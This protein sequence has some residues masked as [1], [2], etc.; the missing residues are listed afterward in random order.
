[1]KSTHFFLDPFTDKVSREFRT[2]IKKLFLLELSVYEIAQTFSSP[3]EE[4]GGHWAFPC[5]ILS[6]KLRKSPAYISEELSQAFEDSSVCEKVFNKGPYMNFFFK[7]DFL[8]KELLDSITT[9]RFFKIPSKK[10]GTYL[11]EYSQPNTHKELHIGH[12]RN[13]CFGLSL[14]T[15]LKKRGFP[16]HTCTYLGDMGTHVAKCLWY[17]KYH[18]KNP[19]PSENQGAW[20]GA[21][22]T[23]SCKA[24]EEVGDEAQLSEILKQLKNK[25]GEFY[26]LWRKTR[27]WSEDLIREIYRWAGVEFDHWYWESEMDVPSI[28]LVK[29]LYKEGKLQLSEGAI[30]MDLGEPLGFCLLLKSDGNGLYATKDLYLIKK[31]FEDY[32]PETN[33]YI[34]DQRQETHFSQVF[35]ALEQLDFKAEAQKSRHLKYNFVEL[36]S[37]AMSSRKGNI[38]PI[39]TLIKNMRT[40]ITDTFLNK[41]KGE[42]SDAKIKTT[43]DLIAQGAIKYGMNEQDLPKKIVFDMKEWLKLDGRSG[44]YIQYAHA[45][46]CTLLKKFSAFE[47]PK[48][49]TVN[50]QFLNTPEEWQLII[51]LSWF[52]LV[53][54]K[55]AWQM[56]TSP[57]CYYL[58]ELAQKFSRFYQN[59]PIGTLDL[60]EQRQF[61][62]F[63]VQA[64]REVLKEGLISLA[65]PAPEK[66]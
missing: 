44:P 63:L 50:L 23:K 56:R 48:E 59:C 29:Q 33:I 43:A 54:E 37:G 42:W 40:Y 61:R 65:I 5:F 31:K 20:L 35:K 32:K 8:K 21:L 15:L 57:L 49:K 14:V 6:Q 64:S 38:V 46:A 24:F 9:G 22:Y 51:H 55:C 18:N 17:L 13:I 12:T 4:T 36:K 53:M 58:F 52:G 10:M 28:D 3:P 41:Y 60:E 45:R 34:V 30:G 1:M 47:S 25:E 26:A 19:L 39:M 11:I 2:K 66:M 27:L 7:K 16:V 62:L